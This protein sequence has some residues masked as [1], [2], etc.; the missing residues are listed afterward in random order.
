MKRAITVCCILLIFSTSLVFAS[1][2]QGRV[3]PK[4]GLIMCSINVAQGWAR[5]S[6]PWPSF[7]RINLQSGVAP[8]YGAKALQTGNALWVGIISPAGEVVAH[9]VCYHG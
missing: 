3:V 9:N 7:S 8:G 6:A 5:A 1:T 4:A 2:R